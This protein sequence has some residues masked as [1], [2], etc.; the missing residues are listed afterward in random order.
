MKV[1][2]AIQNILLIM[3]GFFIVSVLVLFFIFNIHPVVVVSGS[4]EPE[5]AVGSVALVDGDMKEPEIGDVI[6]YRNGKNVV[7]HR[8]VGERDVGYVTKGD[9]N[10]VEDPALVSSTQ[11][12]GTIVY[13]IPGAGKAI[14]YIRTPVGIIIILSAFMCFIMIGQIVKRR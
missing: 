9:S 2:R 13:A 1:Y 14:S 11:L 6:A 4:M 7:T 12:E 8:V 5:I 10:V 3:A